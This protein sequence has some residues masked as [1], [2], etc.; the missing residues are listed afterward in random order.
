M[1][2]NPISVL[3]RLPQPWALLVALAV[4]S[5]PAQADINWDGDNPFGNF[6]FNNNWYGN[7]QP[8]WA[9]TSGNLVFNFN[10]AASTSVYWDYNQWRNINDIIFESTFTGPLVWN[11]DGTGINFNQRLENRSSSAITIGSMNL[12]GAKNGASSIELNPVNGDLILNGSIF[13]DNNRPYSVFGNNGKMLT[14]NTVLG[15]TSA[16]FSVKQDSVVRLGAAQ[17]LTGNTVV[18]AGRLELASTGGVGGNIV[19]GATTGS[20]NAELRLLD[21][22]GGYSE[23][24]GITVNSGSTGTK[25]LSSMNTSGVN[26]LSG[27]VT[28]S[29]SAALTVQAQA[30]GTL[31]LTGVWTGSGA[32]TKTGNGALRLSGSTANTMT[33]NA[34]IVNAGVLELNKSAG[35]ALTASSTVTVANGGVVRWLANGNTNAATDFIVQAGGLVDLDGFNASFAFSGNDRIRLSG[36]TVQTGTGLWTMGGN[37]AN[38]AIVDGSVTSTISGNVKLNAN[39]NIRGIALADNAPGID[40]NWSANINDTGETNGTGLIFKASSGTPSVS[41]GGDNSHRLTAQISAGVTVYADHANALGSTASPAG[42]TVVSGGGTLGLRGGLTYAAETVSLA[43]HPTPGLRSVSGHNI[44]TGSITNPGGSTVAPAGIQVDA[45]T[46]T[47]TGTWG[48]QSSSRPVGKFGPGAFIDSSVAATSQPLYVLGGVYAY[49]AAGRVNTRAGSLGTVLHGGVVA[50]PDNITMALG[51]NAN[52]QRFGT[53][54]GGWAAY[55]GDIQVDVAG[56]TTLTWGGATPAAVPAVLISGGVVTGVNAD[57]VFFGG[58]GYSGTEVVS[59]TGGGGTGASM[60]INVVNGQITGYTLISGGSGYTSAPTLSVAAPNAA[61]GGTTHFLP[62]Q[63]P[64]ILNSNIS[65]HRVVLKDNI[66]LAAATATFTGQ[67]EIRVEDNPNS[68]SDVAVIDTALTS[69]KAGIGLLKTGPGVLELTKPNTY[70]GR[71]TVSAG[72]L[73]LSGTGSLHKDGPV[74][75]SASAAKLNIS[76]LSSLADIG[77]FSGVAGSILELGGNALT[78]GDISDETFSGQVDSTSGA[79]LIKEGSGN[80]TLGSTVSFTGSPAIEIASGTLLTSGNNQIP[81]ASELTLSGGTLNSGGFTESLGSLK[82]TSPSSIN[83][84]GNSLLTFGDSTAQSWSGSLQILNWTGNLA[85][86]GIEQL[87][88]LNLGL[89]NTQLSSITFVDPL[90]LPAGSYPATLLGNELIPVPEPATLWSSLGL[91][92][93]VFWREQRRRR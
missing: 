28:L 41:L 29:A 27:N 38:D 69:A 33:N 70:T 88:F 55:G 73:L 30:G 37:N 8:T 36:G 65:A 43:F 47:F 15:G 14:V 16:S 5:S 79:R 58:S 34:L 76:A 6:S 83:L 2:K 44:W 11:G 67:R 85:G 4:L 20:A 10:N 71:T 52:L 51:A 72:T 21:A 66:N 17:T 12:S 49:T 59:I 60:G 61:D 80:F 77:A 56:T 35:D 9:Y 25:T 68:T 91:L 13:N 87:R 50:S 42:N 48:S 24:A 89:T 45:D 90:G 75:L 93:L 1:Y 92:S 81:D 22:D 40:L 39:G 19:L 78:F 57:Q 74:D 3:T 54:G 62:N 7:N 46:L 32:L 84:A 31:D 86:G 53:N 18:E 82:V 63:A 26:T 23:N 64:L